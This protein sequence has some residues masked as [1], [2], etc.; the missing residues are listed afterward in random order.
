[1]R[2]IRLERLSK[3]PDGVFSHLL[4]ADGNVICCV[5]EHAYDGEPKLPDGT[6]TV[7]LGLH[8][9][10]HGGPQMLYAVE[11]VPGHSGIC[12][13]RGNDP[14]VDSDGCLLLGETVVGYKV[15]RSVAAFDSFMQMMNDE[16]EFTLVVS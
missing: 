13:H 9:L 2:T 5:A 4:N 3:G 8:Q 16:A 14:Q 12:F 11:A 15:I 7:R 1:M 10:D 6:W